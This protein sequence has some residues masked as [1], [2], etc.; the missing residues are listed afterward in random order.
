[1]IEVMKSIRIVRNGE[2]V[3]KTFTVRV[4]NEAAILAFCDVN[5]NINHGKCLLNKLGAVLELR[6]LFAVVNS[7]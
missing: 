6:M 3:K 4:C 7:F 2:Y 5:T 1:M